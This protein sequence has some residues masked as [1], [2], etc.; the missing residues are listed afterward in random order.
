MGTV[1]KSW[2]DLYLDGAVFLNGKKFLANGAGVGA[3]NTV[4]GSEVLISNTTGWS[5]TG[6]GVNALFSNTEG[7]ENTATGY[8]A[9]YGNTTGHANKCFRYV[10]IGE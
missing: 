6:T 1:T 4:V 10:H 8:Y 9:L 3:G 2:R 7:Y 5:N